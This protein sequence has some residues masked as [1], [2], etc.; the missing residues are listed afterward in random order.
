MTSQSRVAATALLIAACGAGPAAAQTPAAPPAPGAA[1]GSPQA[2]AAQNCPVT[3]DRLVDALKKSVKASGG[4]GNGGFDT[5]EWAVAMARDGT[6]CAVAYSGGRLSDQWLNSRAIAA[7]KANTANGFSLKERALSTAN[8]YAGAQPGGFLFGIGNT[9][10]V[11]AEVINAGDAK[12][13]GTVSD[14][15]VGKRV[16]GVVVFGGGLALYN[17]GDAVGG[18]GVS[19]DSSCADHNVAWRI[20]KALGLDHVTAGPGTNKNDGIIYDIGLTGSSK[21]GFGHPKCAGTEADIAKDIEAVG[22]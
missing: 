5:N 8:L 22:K 20:R 6:V 19:G 11:N 21:S 7:Q 15:M 16:G 14:P 2:S 18:L 12:Q 10:P 3:H 4:P 9:D 17:E 1:Q 13:F